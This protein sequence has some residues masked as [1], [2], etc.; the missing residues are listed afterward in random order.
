MNRNS[1]ESCTG[2]EA[3][4]GAVLGYERE[5]TQNQQSVWQ[6]LLRGGTELLDEQH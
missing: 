6:L 5:K 3:A 1:S 2:P 4:V